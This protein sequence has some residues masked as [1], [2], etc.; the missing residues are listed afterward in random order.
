MLLN[1]PLNCLCGAK[2]KLKKKN[3][4]VGVKYYLY[5]CPNCEDAITFATRLQEFALE[6][7]NSSVTRKKYLL[8]KNNRDKEQKIVN[9]Q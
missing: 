5:Q 4:A 9:K 8:D 2:P 6:N 7:W 1:K 3:I